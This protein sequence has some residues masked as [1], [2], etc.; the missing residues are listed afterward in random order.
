MMYHTA[1]RR[2][3]NNKYQQNFL[4]EIN[5]NFECKVGPDVS[6]YILDFIKPT[7]C[8]RCRICTNKIG[9]KYT[10]CLHKNCSNKICHSCYRKT[11]KYNRYKPYCPR[12]FNKYYGKRS[13]IKDVKKMIYKYD[14]QFLHY[15]YKTHTTSM[16]Q[17]FM[18]RF[19]WYGECF[20][21]IPKRKYICC[22]YSFKVE[23]NMLTIKLA[24]SIYDCIEYEQNS[25]SKSA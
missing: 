15:M 18:F 4:K 2:Y 7:K 23:E 6:K 9:Q 16:I 5:R 11:S 19:H 3:L 14:I 8:R 12:H 22:N 25:R 21:P 17:D 10:Y 20:I 24:D 1:N 13:L